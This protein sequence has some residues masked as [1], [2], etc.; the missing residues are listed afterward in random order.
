MEIMDLLRGPVLGVILMILLM[1][2]VV[3]VAAF[4][5]LMAQIGLL[6]RWRVPPTPSREGVQPSQ[7]EPDD[8][9]RTSRI[10]PTPQVVAADERPDEWWLEKIRKT[11]D[12]VLRR[13]PCLTSLQHP[14]CQLMRQKRGKTMVK[15][16]D[17]ISN[18]IPWLRNRS[19]LCIPNDLQ[20]HATEL[21]YND[22]NELEYILFHVTETEGD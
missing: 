16:L 15:I 9:P 1:A 21:S 13:T 6:F 3:L 7:I 11:E 20:V 10:H 4:A 22:Q 8:R 12:G 5:A 14:Y 2:G 18:R 19:T 17:E